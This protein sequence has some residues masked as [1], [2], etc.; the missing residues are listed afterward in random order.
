MLEKDEKISWTDRVNN[1]VL[2]RVKEET[3]F[4]RTIKRR[5][6]NWIRGAPRGGGGGGGGRP[7]PTPT[8]NK[9]KNNFFMLNKK[10]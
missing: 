3:N 1:G 4:L 8:K 10:I 7:R 6:P 9:K 2:H 5:K